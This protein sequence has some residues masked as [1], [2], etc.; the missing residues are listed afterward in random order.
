MDG[1]GNT[2]F[3][4][5]LN[6]MEAIK[7]NTP[8]PALA[9]HLFEHGEPDDLDQILNTKLIKDFKIYRHRVHKENPAHPTVDIYEDVKIKI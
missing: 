1:S 4:F 3:A 5:S 8:F 7:Q 9:M 2:R 6:V